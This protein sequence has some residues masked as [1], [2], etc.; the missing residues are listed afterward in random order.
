LDWTEGRIEWILDGVSV[1]VLTNDTAGL[2]FSQTPGRVTIGIW[3]PACYSAT[4]GLVGIPVSDNFD[5]Y[6]ATVGTLEVINYNPATEYTYSDMSGSSSSV[7]IHQGSISKLTRGEI[8]GIVVAG[9]GALV[10]IVGALFYWFRRRSA[11][12]YGESQHDPEPEIVADKTGDVADEQRV[13]YPENLERLEHEVEPARPGRRSEAPAGGRLGPDLAVRPGGRL[14][15]PSEDRPGGR[16][17][18][19]VVDEE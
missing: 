19:T 8:A 17:N 1:A 4:P 7:V 3:C 13:R 11:L 10:I 6:V 9:V 16:L 14:G 2:G 5:D 15:L 12:N 18:G